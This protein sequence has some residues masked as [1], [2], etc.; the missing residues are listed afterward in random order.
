MRRTRILL[1]FTIAV[2]ATAPAFAGGLDLRLGAFFP[3][4]DSNLF[5]DDA[6][7]Y[8]VGGKNDWIGPAGGAELS[9]DLARSVELGFHVDGYGRTVHTAY[10]DFETESGRD[11][12][13][14][15]K[16]SIVPFGVSVRFHP[17][18]R[19]G[20][21]TPYVGGGFDLYYWRYEEF[22]DFIDFDS[23]GFD[24]LEDS[25]VSDG[26]T[27]GF[28]VAGG[29]R[30]PINYDWSVVTEVRYNFARADMGGDFRG[31]KLDL[32]GITAAV[33]VNLR[34]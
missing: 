25:F 34:F 12:T 27:P 10:R 28:H 6:V 2:L 1:T 21:L 7:L 30:I 15:L 3:R 14:S 18:D 8:T 29:L 20:R 16:L 19:R 9:L 31:N 22:G 24:I 4:A 32:N 26:V 17:G 33:G 23:P 13:Q 5:D 11:I